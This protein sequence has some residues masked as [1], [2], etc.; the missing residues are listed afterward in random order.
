M[1]AYISGIATSKDATFAA[2]ITTSGGTKEYVYRYNGTTINGAELAALLFVLNGVTSKA[3]TSL[4]VF[5]N[6]KYI[7][8]MIERD[9]T[10]K[11]LKQAI[12]NKDLVD[13]VRAII[14]A[15]KKFSFTFDKDSETFMKVRQ[16]ARVN[17]TPV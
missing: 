7:Q 11:W 14:P 12:S 3:T 16:L 4:N 15:L 10:G 17:P 6:S 2:I 13:K 1:D 8:S 5:T 9:A